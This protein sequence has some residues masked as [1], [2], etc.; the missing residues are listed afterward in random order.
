M[1][2]KTFLFLIIVFI[3]TACSTQITAKPSSAT[4]IVSTEL[5]PTLTV[6]ITSTQPIV[7]TTTQSPTP[8]PT[9]Q[10]TI[11]FTN[12]S[13]VYD[14][15]ALLD[16][17]NEKIQN[18]TGMGSYSL[19]WSP[20]GQWIA[21]NGG[22]PLTQSNSTPS[23]N[24]DIFIIKPDGTEVKRFT[25]SFQGK[26]DV[27]WSPDKEFIV[28][29]YDN[30]TG[31]SDLALIDIAHEKT[32]L[33]TSTNQYESHPSWAPNGKNIAYLSSQIANSKNEL[34]LIDADEKNPK[35]V[36]DIPIIFG[37]I[38]WSPD[39]EWIGFTS[40]NKSDCGNVY[41]IKPDGSKLT[42]LTN[43]TSCAVNITWSPDGKYLAFTEKSN[44]ASSSDNWESQIDI[45]DING[46]YIKT[47]T[48]KNVWRINDLDW[49]P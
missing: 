33:L 38:D 9:L 17:D 32:F 1:K 28:Y 10:G 22:I 5:I 13:R 7:P 11:A 26:Y 46:Q 40:G 35:M 14:S 47:F 20:D 16:L 6:T 49:K 4:A 2:H 21:F 29:T 34:W 12:V 18:V 24:I 19:S 27:N 31:P 36:I 3:S 44:S 30:H 25:N 48:I 15:I 39:G 43:E 37:R 41:I 8:L 45:I 23:Q 42:Q